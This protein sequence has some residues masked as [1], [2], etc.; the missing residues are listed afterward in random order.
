MVCFL[1][2]AS[3]DTLHL[4]NSEEIVSAVLNL[5]IINNVN[6][7]IISTLCLV[8]SVFPKAWILANMK[9]SVPLLY[10]VF[11]EE[12]KAIVDK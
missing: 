10:F 3:N 9:H 2:A 8:P 12:L 5:S 6:L 11:P 1:Y 7:P 4:H